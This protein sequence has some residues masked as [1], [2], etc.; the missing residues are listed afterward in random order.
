MMTNPLM[1]NRPSSRS[2]FSMGLGDVMQYSGKSQR[3]HEK[4]M[5]LE[6]TAS[7]FELDLVGAANESRSDRAVQWGI[8]WFYDASGNLKLGYRNEAV[9]ANRK[10]QNA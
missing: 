8:G 6:K 4:Y 3:G 9:D 7:G 1:G 5:H 10:A 2:Y